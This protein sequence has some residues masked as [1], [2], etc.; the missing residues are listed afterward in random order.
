MSKTA[1]DARREAERLRE[2]IRRHDY[3]YYVEARPEVSDT[4]YDKLM[5]RLQDLETEHPE[6]AS[7]DSP[8]RRVGGFAPT[9]FAP[10]THRTPMLSLDNT[11][12]P[13]EFREWHERAKKVLKGDPGALVVEM[14]IDGLSMSLLYEDGVL[15]TA[16]TRGDGER[17]E[18]VTP[19]V[20]TIRA[21]PLRLRKPSKGLI[22]V[23]G[24]VYMDKK[25]FLAFNE[26][27]KAAGRE[28]F[29]NPRNA[30]AGGIR[31][32]DSRVT[33]QR[34]LKFFAHSMG[35]TEGDASYKTHWDY[36]QHVR[37]LGFAIPEAD[38]LFDSAD[39]AVKYYEKFEEKRL[40]LPYEID[41]LVVKVNDL[42]KQRK[43]GWT[44]K[45][46]RWAIAF[47]YASTQATTIVR[48]VIFSVGRTGTI[49][50][51]AELEPVPCGGVTIS[52]VSLHN[53]EEVKR[54][55][56][57]VGD[58]VLIERAGEVIPHVV[59]VIKAK[60][61][62]SASPVEPPSKCPDCGGKAVKEEE[63]VALQCVNPS[64]PAQ[65][66][67][68]LQYFASR[69][70][71]DIE[72]MG[73]AVVE[74]LVDTKTVR[75][76]AD[77]YDLEKDELLKLEGFADKKAENLLAAIAASKSRPLSRLVLA[78]GVR[79]VGE[80][81]A[82]ALAR[83]FRS[84]KDL[85]D[86]S[87]ERLEQVQDVGPVVAETVHTFFR[88]PQALE[89]IK[90]LERHKLN[91]TEPEGPKAPA[92]SPVAGKTFVFTGELESMPRIEAEETV[93]ALGG[94]ASGSVSKKTSYVVVGASA[95]SKAE[96][97]K[98]LGLAILSEA[99]FLMLIGK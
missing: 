27:E 42:E 19:N 29:A 45:S 97:A 98:K 7:S 2:Q 52:N 35:L 64:C 76:F 48:N 92:G 25:D 17:G 74:Q 73:E 63:L 93:R 69:D 57:H 78:L 15:I 23:R 50:P 11:Y 70:A 18:D 68:G 21:V 81:M 26:A 31:Q 79:H 94:E 59:N 85:K 34:P 36:L 75:T 91:M 65:L 33:A 24:E 12:N 80:A 13:D 30:A 6:L 37:A 84:M 89:L 16:A 8:T 1:P 43:L 28:P 60:R 95:G 90:Q 82:R 71:M 96:K 22:E 66:K 51:V 62:R 32:K 46:P 77:I 10:V 86:A 61:P 3:L 67:R 41:G 49:T 54:L 44:S 4:E 72:G 56:L 40:S 39:D 58:T 55:D 83:H 99:E 88:Q 47:K 5:R 38:T 9:D 14:K 53:F 87:L 20:R